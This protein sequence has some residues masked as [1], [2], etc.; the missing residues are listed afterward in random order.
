MGILL[1]IPIG[2][3]YNL[4]IS[5]LGNMLTKDLGQKERTQKNLI[6]EIIGGIV[7][8]VLAYWVFGS[9]KFENKIVK[10]GLIFGGGLLLFYSTISNWD[11]IE[12]G[13]KLFT[14]LSVMIFMIIYSYKYIKN[15]TKD[16]KLDL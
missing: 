2:I 10:W 9:K 13:T 8:L 4:M 7:A 12:D 14:L 15:N 6:V 5:K 3:I 11:I 1:S 16:K